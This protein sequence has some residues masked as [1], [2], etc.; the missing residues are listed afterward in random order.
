MTAWTTPAD[1]LQRL[2]RRWDSGDLL[3]RLGSGAEW[4]PI[5][6]GL[7]APG[8]GE[9]AAHLAAAQRWAASWASVPGL[10]LERR[11]VGG[12]LVG[13]NEL[14]AKVWV[15]GYDQ[16]W[17]ALGV[18]A[19]VEE[20]VRLLADTQRRAPRLAGWVLAHPLRLL[21]LAPVWGAL[22]D[23]VGWI[24]RHAGRPIY[25]RQVDVAGVD[26]KF[27]QRHQGI[28]ADLLDLQL[29]AER[30]DPAY[31]RSDFAA[32]YRF[33]SRPAYLRL[34]SLDP[35]R[36]LAGGYTELTVCRDELVAHPP[37]HAEVY[38]V[39]NEITYLAFP[40]VPDAIAVFGGGYAVSTVEPVCWLDQRQLRYWGDIDTHGFAILDRLRQHFPHARSMLMDRATL[41]AHESQWVREPKPV[42]TRL[43][44]LHPDEADLYRDLVEDSL[45]GAVRLE[46]ERISYA[47]VV[48]H[49][50]DSRTGH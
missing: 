19:Q 22:I 34:R 8:A 32:R 15:D 13:V 2:R 35:D 6:F 14:P 5:A 47:A 44:H 31:P 7:R 23:T 43:G 36:P 12:R 9:L 10:R 24:D 49:L 48:A 41:L 45:G 16:A 37:P 17:T 33:R 30:V 20:F 18:A 46:Q 25:L 38:V 40:P 42:V 11:R 26:T 1:V 4:E 39:E 3:R 29:A 50:R 28:L 27:I 21:E